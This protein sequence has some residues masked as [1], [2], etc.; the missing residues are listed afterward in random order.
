[1][2]VSECTGR[3]TKEEKGE[4]PHG[5]WVSAKNIGEIDRGIK[6]SKAGK[7]RDEKRLYSDH[8][9]GVNVLMV[10]GSVS[11]KSDQLEDRIVWYLASRNGGETATE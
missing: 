3:G 2:F 9:G 1:M 4:N 11:F 5:A 6:R 7:S 10:D 8:Y